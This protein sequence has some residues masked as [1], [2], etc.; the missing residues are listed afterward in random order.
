MSRKCP[1]SGKKPLSGNNRSHSMHA[2]KRVQ[3]VNLQSFI[4]EKNGKKERVKMSARAHRNF[5]KQNS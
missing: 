2:T 1:I 3:N 5:I 4:I